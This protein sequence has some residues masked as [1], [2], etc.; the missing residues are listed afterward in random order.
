MEE[1]KRQSC[2]KVGERCISEEV[3]MVR[4]RLASMTGFPP[5]SKMMSG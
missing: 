4:D 1:T 5:D 3:R 2:S